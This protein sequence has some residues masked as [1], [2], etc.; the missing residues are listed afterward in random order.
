[1]AEALTAFFSVFV[2]PYLLLLI[3]VTTIA[4]W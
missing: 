3:L 4:G 1:M 2:D